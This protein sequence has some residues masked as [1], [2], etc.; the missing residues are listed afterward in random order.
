MQ[1][2]RQVTVGCTMLIGTDKKGVLRPDP[3]GYYTVPLGA[4][5][6]YNSMGMFYDFNSAA[7]L[8][9]DGSPLMRMIQ[10]GVLRAEYK[11]PERQPGQSDQE[12]IQRIRTIDSD[13]V[14][15]HIRRAYLREGQRDEQ[16]RPIVTVMGEVRPS[17]PFG[18]ILKDALDNPHENVYFSVRS[19]TMDDMVRG[20]KYTREI[21]TWDYVNEGG[22]Y[23]ANKYN[24]PALES[25]GEVQLT[26]TLLWEMAEEQKRQQQLGLETGGVDYNALAKDLG[27]NKT[28]TSIKPAIYSQW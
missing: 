3:D 8:F 17:G 20:I 27:W 12:Y 26:P 16:G 19:L 18:H 7:A 1:A 6:A 21:I 5:G 11:H 10:K 28:P 14:C 24:S 15:A 9:K 22:I 25:F 13:R 2:V 23:T 4:Y